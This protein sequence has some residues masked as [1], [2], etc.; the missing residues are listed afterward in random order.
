MQEAGED[1]ESEADI[2]DP[3][4]FAKPDVVEVTEEHTTGRPKPL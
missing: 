4:V 2:E 3:L 1:G